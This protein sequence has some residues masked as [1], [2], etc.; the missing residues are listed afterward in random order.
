M[1]TIRMNSK[2]GNTFNP[3]RLVLNLEDKVDL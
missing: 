2:N 1:R 3:D